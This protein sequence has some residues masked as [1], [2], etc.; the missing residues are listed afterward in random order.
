MSIGL[1]VGEEIL[2]KFMVGYGPDKPE[3]LYKRT[4]DAWLTD[5]RLLIDAPEGPV[6][7]P[8]ASLEDVDYLE[9]EGDL[10]KVRIRGGITGELVVLRREFF[11]K[12]REVLKPET[13]QLYR[14]LFTL[15]RGSQDR[16]EIFTDMRTSQV[17]FGVENMLFK[18]DFSKLS[19]LRE[20]PLTRA[21]DRFIYAALITCI[22]GLFL[23]I[24]YGI[25]M[26]AIAG[27]LLLF[28]AA[29]AEA[30]VKYEWWK[31]MGPFIKKLLRFGGTIILLA[32]MLS[33]LKQMTG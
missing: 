6:S 27:T 8:Y 11:P 14:W 29:A 16:E 28:A 21:V 33:V 1:E 22:I 3:D 24:A 7:F 5:K 25:H 18:P 19:L 30:K 2:L 12:R 23:A 13:E 9:W 20:T 26:V 4:C 32:V 31:L 15:M 10:R 17:I